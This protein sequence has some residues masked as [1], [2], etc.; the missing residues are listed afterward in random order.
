MVGGL[1]VGSSFIIAII[2]K[3]ENPEGNIP[4]LRNISALALHF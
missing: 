1:A 4:I 2:K 3:S